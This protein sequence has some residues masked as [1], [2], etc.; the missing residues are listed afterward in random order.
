M[1]QRELTVSGL[2]AEV[3]V[4]PLFEQVAQPRRAAQHARHVVADL[5]IVLPRLVMGVVHVV[6]AGE[7]ADLS[8]LET[9]ELGHLSQDGRG[10][11]ADLAL[12]DVQRRAQRRA[13]H[14]VTGL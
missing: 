13:G 3:N 6:E 12:G 11:P 2:L 9:E 14:G 5:D 4:Q 10:Q 8:H 7:L 1:A